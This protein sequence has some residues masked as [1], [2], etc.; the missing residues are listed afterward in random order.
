[1]RNF[2]LKLTAFFWLLLPVSLLPVY[3]EENN[4]YSN[5]DPKIFYTELQG[6]NDTGQGVYDGSEKDNND[7][8][9]VEKGTHEGLKAVISPGSAKRMGIVI[10]EAV[11]ANVSQK[12]SL[13]GRITINQNAI[14]DVHGRFSGIVRN[15]EVNLGEHV[16]KGQ[17]LAT[18]EANDSLQEYNV[19]APISGVILE[20]NTNI[21]D[22]VGEHPIFV[23][24]DLSNVWAKFH[25][26]LRDSDRVQIGQNIAVYNLERDKTAPGKIDMFY[27]T[28]D[29]KS[30]TQVVIVVLP[31]PERAWK[32]GMI[33]EGDVSVAK[34][35]VDV[36][37]KEKAL[38]KMEKFGDVVFVK[39]G[40]FFIPKAVKIG[41]KENG[42]VEIIKGLKAGDL[43][44]SDG[45]FIV[46]SD[47]LKATASH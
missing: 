1:M 9:T 15:V 45:S 46:K 4:K 24:A 10:E 22:L 12:I 6:R 3:A 35:D 40:K 29:E 20:R 37:V 7:E 17:I 14:A 43:Y 11:S 21:G 31:N 2:L 47:I 38:Q 36:S 42:T 8:R 27:P 16:Q 39:E 5:K 44:V 25:V 30:Q 41:R 34:S 23:I 13:T 26:F 18:V 19:V 32:P 28:T 33:I